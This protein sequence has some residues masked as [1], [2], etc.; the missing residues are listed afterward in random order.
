[1]NDARKTILV[2]DDEPDTVT[3]LTA[4]LEDNGYRV[5]SAP[6]GE[7]GL[8]ATRAER[9]DLISLDIT[10][11]QKSGVKF[12]REL[13]SDADLGSIPVVMVTGVADDFKQFISGRKQVPPP[14]GYISKP[15]DVKALL[16]T[17]G[18]ILGS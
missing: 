1:M 4:L 5:I 9:P 17:L 12:Y 15:I 13:K 11:P 7:K 14:D 8:E 16:E 2:I 10:M 3:F 6:D 18:K